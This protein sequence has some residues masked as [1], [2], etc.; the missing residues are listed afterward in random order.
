MSFHLAAFTGPN[1]MGVFSALPPI[2]DPSLYSRSDGI[3]LPNSMDV[4]CAFVKGGNVSAARITSP[5]LRAVSPIEIRPISATTTIP[6]N[7]NVRF[8]GYGA[9]RLSD[10]EPAIL[11][12]MGP[13]QDSASGLL[14]LSDRFEPIPTGDQ[15]WVR[16]TSS[17]SVWTSGMWTPIDVTMADPLAA[18]SYA[19]VGM[20]YYSPFG[21]AAR[22]TFDCQY[23][24]PGTLAIQAVSNRTFPQS[25]D[26]SFGVWGTFRTSSLPR[27]EVLIDGAAYE[28]EIRLLV[29]RLR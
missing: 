8:L 19:V 16:L 21:L 12:A 4:V 23:W 24:R 2:R 5:T 17:T 13:I 20:Q 10:E 28:H 11:Q 7:P 6:T 9:A 3:V 22:L 27:V 29:T 1:G 26:G 25:Y 15:Y 14:W 18:G